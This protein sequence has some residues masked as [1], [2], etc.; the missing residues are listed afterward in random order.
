[1]LSIRKKK[2]L[3][4][5]SSLIVLV[6]VGLFTF[7]GVFALSY[8]N[9]SKYVNITKEGE[10][11]HGSYTV[12]YDEL[13]NPDDVTTSNAVSKS[14][15]LAHFEVAAD[16]GYYVDG[17]EVRFND[18]NL[19]TGFIAGAETG[20]FFR[21]YGFSFEEY[22]Y[23]FF[24]PE[25][26]TESNKVEVTIHYSEKES[27]DISYMNYLGNEYDPDSIRDI[28][29][30]SEVKTLVENYRDGDLILPADAVENGSV[31]IF[32]F[33][34]EYYDNITNN[35]MNN[36][37]HF[38]A[39]AVILFDGRNDNMF[40]VECDDE[41]H[42]CYVIVNKGFNEISQGRIYFGYNDIKVYMPG[43]VGFDSAGDVNN[44]ND[45][46]MGFGYTSESHE[47]YINQLFYGTKKLY[48]SKVVPQP[49]VNSGANNCGSFGTFDNVTGSGYGYSV[50][51]NANVATISISS[52]YQDIMTVE[53]NI[54]NGSTNIFGGP[55]KLH[56]NRY[57]FNEAMIETDAT[58]RNCQENNNGNTCNQGRYYSVEYRGVLSSFYTESDEE[59][60]LESIMVIDNVDDANHTVDLNNW[61]QNEVAYLRNK[62]FTP[63]VLALFYDDTDMI[64]ATRTFD[65]NHDVPASGFITRENFLN[66]YNGYTFNMEV[67]KDY[68]RV[69][70]NI[71]EL[72][73]EKLDYFDH[74]D[75][76]AIMHYIVLMDT[77]EARDLNV[78]RVAIFL[79]NGEIEENA[80]PSLTYGTNEGRVFQL[81]HEEPNGGEQ[82]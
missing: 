75:N 12:R 2:I 82:P 13:L 60:Q 1:M 73:I 78:Q 8:D 61:N 64:V 49:I 21:E 9:P 71:G 15:I 42:V 4:K 58:G 22:V 66:Q 70:H 36:G 18:Q 59:E 14:N 19:V 24:I 37:G 48:L 5:K 7:I 77:E 62:N 33:S 44:F 34:E 68:I 31:L 51:Y 63:N 72:P 17:F 74:I 40:N 10:E 45:S 65:L 67:N 11:T 20:A 76:A 56:L 80:I 69:D 81:R 27:F 53:L 16:P 38:N 26:A 41:N 35:Q 23:E 3:A 29:N 43:Y 47:A 54:M 79:I 32:S 57:A 39:E 30:Y 50:S 25:T 28:N 55:V 52:Y 46:N 6:L